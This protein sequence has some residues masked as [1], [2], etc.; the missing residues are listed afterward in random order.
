[1]EDNKVHEERK[2]YLTINP[3]AKTY[4]NKDDKYK[5]K[6]EKLM[7]ELKY[8]NKFNISKSEFMRL[9]G[10]D[11]EFYCHFLLMTYVFK[12]ASTSIRDYIGLTRDFESG[13]AEMR[14]YFE[15]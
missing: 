1:M 10:E 11:E 2:D 7:Q 3:P 14:E 13:M 4:I 8:H 6:K 9:T 5:D 15:D 12:N